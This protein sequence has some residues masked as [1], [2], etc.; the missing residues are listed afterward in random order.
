MT[1]ARR[2]LAVLLAAMIGLAG[3]GVTADGEPEL[4]AGDEIPDELL[5]PNPTTSTTRPGATAAVTVYL[6]QRT[7]STTQLVPVVRE[8]EDPS[9]PGERIEALLQPTTEE[10]KARGLTSSIPA[11]T[12]L[13][14]TPSLDVE[15]QELTLDFSEELF[16]VEGTELAQAFGQ[17]VWTVTELEGVR[18]V[19]FLVEG[20][21]QR[22][23]DA[24]GVEQDGA[25]STA[26]YWSLR[27]R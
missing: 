9:R 19:L 27:P 6:L 22:A 5:D 14:G 18:R 15:R 1:G 25:V 13:L 3:C 24:D 2:A 12:V 8:V 20:E 10:E 26:D 4:I 16:S 21:P 17:I 11:D 23:P 7:G